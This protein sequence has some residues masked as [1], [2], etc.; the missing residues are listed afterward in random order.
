MPNYL[1]REEMNTWQEKI[2]IATVLLDFGILVNLKTGHIVYSLLKRKC[3]CTRLQLLRH[4]KTLAIERNEFMSN[5]SANSVLA[6]AGIKEIKIA[7]AQFSNEPPDI[8]LL[9]PLN[10][11]ISTFEILKKHM[12]VEL[13]VKTCPYLLGINNSVWEEKTFNMLDNE[14]LYIFLQRECSH[15]IFAKTRN[16]D[17]WGDVL[18]RCAQLI[19][20]LNQDYIN[21]KVLLVSQGS[22]YQ[23][24]KILLHHNKT[25]WDG[26]SA[27]TMF[28]TMNSS[29]K[30]IGYGRIFDIC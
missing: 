27:S 18:V 9:A 3:K 20:A 29:Q 10:R 30:S 5:D 22:I 4:G 1:Q 28:C 2:I 11:T 15:N 26:Y 23:G 6:D 13:P 7:A 12:S 14:N 21:K 8:I 25:P 17:S 16:G 24:L 19:K